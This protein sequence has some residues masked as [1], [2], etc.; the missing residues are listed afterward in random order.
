MSNAGKY[1]IE[2]PR[3]LRSLLEKNPITGKKTKQIE[4]ADYLGVTPQAVSLY[5][6][7]KVYPEWLQVLKIADFFEVSVEYLMTGNIPEN[8]N[9]RDTLKLS[10][11][12]IENLEAVASGKYEGLLFYVDKLLSNKEFYSQLHNA[13]GLFET[14]GS[15]MYILHKNVNEHGGMSEYLLN[16]LLGFGEYKAATGLTNFLMSF[17]KSQ[18]IMRSR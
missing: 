3:I 8:K 5:C 15:L 9:I 16:D 10:E 7:G 18:N 6:N 14:N 12:A 4:L 2:F 1:T 17:F 11:P 13:I